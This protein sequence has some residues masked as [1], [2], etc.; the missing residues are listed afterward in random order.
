MT[1][2]CFGHPVRIAALL[3]AVVALFFGGHALPRVSGWG[4]MIFPPDANAATAVPSAATP[5]SVPDVWKA[6]GRV[7]LQ[8]EANQGQADSQVKFLARGLGYTVFLT[9]SEAVLMLRSPTMSE[10]MPL[11]EA[12]GLGRLARVE[13]EGKNPPERGAT[14]VRLNL[15]GA[16]PEPEVAGLEPLPGKVNYFIGNDPNK[17]HVDIP[18]Y[19]KVGYR[20]VYPGV[21]VVYY[22]A[23]RRLEYDFVVAPGADPT[24]ITMAVTG[25]ETLGVDATGDLLI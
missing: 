1:P 16:N 21:D 5:A 10:D 7:P 19:A 11:P 25:A 24:R 4:S 23:Q 17:W 22:G 8:F 12:P 14:V 15:V 18:T 13:H 9:P 3:V 2:Y 20:N 6:Y